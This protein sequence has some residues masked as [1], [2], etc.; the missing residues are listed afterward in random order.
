MRFAA[1]V[2]LLSVHFDDPSSVSVS[3]R[4]QCF[5]LPDK[6]K[7]RKKIEV[8]SIPKRAE[9]LR[10]T[11]QKEL[12]MVAQAHEEHDNLRLHQGARGRYAPPQQLFPLALAGALDRPDNPLQ[13][14]RDADGFY[15]VRQRTTGR[16]VARTADPATLQ[17][18][19]AT[20]SQT[21]PE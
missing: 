19:L 8:F 4:G 20:L 13:I 17:R 5:A 3:W 12:L 6:A 9:H 10:Q 18:L 15:I 2:L 14:E 7:H 16:L 11:R 21:A 1:T